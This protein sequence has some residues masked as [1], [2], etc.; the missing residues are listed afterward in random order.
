VIALYTMVL[1][2]AEWRMWCSL[3]RIPAEHQSSIPPPELPISCLIN[4]S[5][6]A[7]MK[8]DSIP[9]DADIFL[10]NPPTSVISNEGVLHSVPPLKVTQT[11]VNMLDNA[12][13]DGMTSESL[14]IPGIDVFLPIWILSF[15]ERMGQ[16]IDVQQH[17]RHADAWVRNHAMSA[18]LRSTIIQDAPQ[19]LNGLPW[20]LPLKGFIAGVSI[21]DLAGFLS[22]RLVNTSFIDAVMTSI[23]SKVRR[24]PDLVGK[25][26]VQDLTFYEV[27][28]LPDEWWKRYDF[29]CTFTKLQALGDALADGNLAQ[30]IAP[31][32]IADIHWD[33]FL[34]DAT[35]Q[36]IQYGDPLGWS[37]PQEVVSLL[38][39]WLQ[40]HG[41]QSFMIGPPLPHR[42]QLD[43]FSCSVAMANI[44]RHILFGDPLFNDTEKHFFLI[45]E[46]VN[47]MIPM[48]HQIPELTS[49]NGKS[50][51]STSQ[52]TDSD[53]ESDL[54]YVDND[55][56]SISQPSSSQKI[57]MSP[58][59]VA[60]LPA[61]Q[62]NSHLKIA[63]PTPL[64]KKIVDCKARGGPGLMQYFSKVPRED[65]LEVIQV[66]DEETCEEQ[67]DNAR[68]AKEDKH[69][70]EYE[71]VAKKRLQACEH[72]QRLHA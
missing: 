24:V 8:M 34:V 62:S 61:V 4:L 54:E 39:C 2:S 48:S 19:S 13:C 3:L 29:E 6:P 9:E 55:T 12:L 50:L 41:F 11:L 26:S 70:K 66:K 43:S 5:L 38:N 49:A 52:T 64:I 42:K 63:K 1:S 44:V 59:M 27:L 37:V 28:C 56:I 14:S 46:F 60:S 21:C 33:L 10:T 32:N 47:M 45:Q 15:W 18:H 31:V 7:V 36:E 20:D 40:Q 16:A 53:S 57:K 51:P 68:I 71:K 25:V 69:I 22:E 17:W 30:I 35:T 65:F 58:T 72:K 67:A 23:A